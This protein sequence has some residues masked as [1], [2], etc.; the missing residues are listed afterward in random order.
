M[1]AVLQ[2]ALCWVIFLATHIGMAMAGV[3]TR[4]VRR[5]GEPG[6]MVVFSLV[7]S[8]AFALL[9]RGYAVVRSAGPAGLALGGVPVV[10]WLLVGAI[11]IGMALMVGAFAP[12][13]YWSSPMMVLVGKV[14]EPYGLERISRHPF[15]SGFV[16]FNLAHML[17]AR[18]LT[19]MLFF[20]GFV[21][22]VVAGSAH[23]ASKLRAR[24]GAGYD[25]F[26]AVT[27]A[28]PFAAILAGRQ[29][30]ALREMPWLF[31][32]A[33][34]AGAFGLRAIHGSIMA[35]DGIGFTLAVVLVSWAIAVNAL[36]RRP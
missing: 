16:I 30:L 1:D 12:R 35:R 6:F 29:R 20:G 19:G 23:M 14:R 18:R 15:F 25:D 7:A 28:L 36:R 31:L 10:R 4:L 24:Y 2:V 33:G 9:V 17:L 32:V 8:A 3:R 34:V 11:V 22:L 13:G 21:V 5:L 27:S 26:L